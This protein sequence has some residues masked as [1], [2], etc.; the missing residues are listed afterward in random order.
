MVLGNFCDKLFDIEEI[1]CRITV[2][3]DLLEYNQKIFDP[4]FV[5]SSYFNVPK[6]RRNDGKTRVLLKQAPKMFV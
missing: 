5:Y 4:S 1:W 6:R 2:V 3:D